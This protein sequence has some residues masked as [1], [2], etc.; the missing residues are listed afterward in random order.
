MKGKQEVVPT[1]HAVS[2]AV[3]DK[4][5][6]CI[7][8]GE[9]GVGEGASRQTIEQILETASRAIRLWKSSTRFCSTPCAQWAICLARA[10]CSFRPCSIRRE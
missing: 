6:Y 5:K 7:I 8:Q 9:K 1:A 2:L 10:R 3:E 4:L